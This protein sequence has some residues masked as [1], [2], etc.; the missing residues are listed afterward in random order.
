MKPFG[1]AEFH[2]AMHRPAPRV[3]ELAYLQAC[4]GDAA[5]L[6]LQS[7]PLVG[8]VFTEQGPMEVTDAIAAFDV[9][10]VVYRFGT[11]VVTDDGIACL[12]RHYPLTR[13]RLKEHEDW[14]GHVAEQTWANLWDLV[15]ALVVAQQSGA[16]Q[17]G[18]G[19]Y[20]DDAHSS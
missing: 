15:R 13:A 12:T 8:T 1:D 14:A 20:G 9:G 11:W 10:T 4:L 5:Q 6:L 3:A 19:P 18:S 16:R 2:T 7:Q 17:Q